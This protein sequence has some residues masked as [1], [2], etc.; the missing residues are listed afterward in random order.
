MLR[1]F[2]QEGETHQNQSHYYCF[3]CGGRYM[4]CLVANFRLTLNSWPHRSSQ[5]MFTELQSQPAL[6]ERKQRLCELRLPR[7]ATRL[8]SSEW[9]PESRP[10]ATKASSGPCLNSTTRVRM[11]WPLVSAT[12]RSITTV[13]LTCFPSVSP[14][15]ITV[16]SHPTQNPL[17]CNPRG[18]EDLTLLEE[19]HCN[20]SVLGQHGSGLP[21]KKITSPTA[22]ISRFGSTGI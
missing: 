14:S 3:S 16:F 12:C 21:M 5:Y 8:L 7:K 18:W 6:H 20:N 19:K 17:I 1:I 11:A 2:Q 22:S 4:C 9:G 10:S 13:P 15:C